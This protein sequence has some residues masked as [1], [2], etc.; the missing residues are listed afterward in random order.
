VGYVINPD[1]E[2]LIEAASLG[3]GQTIYLAWTLVL[4]N[5]VN[6]KMAY[7]IYYSTEEDQVFKEGVK[8]VSIDG[9]LS[10]NIPDFIPGQ[11]Y[12]FAVRG[13]EYDP[14]FVDLTLL[15]DAFNGLKVYPTSL[16]RSDIGATD[17]LIPLV[18]TFDFPIFGIVQVGVELVFYS[19]ID[20]NNDNLNVPSGTTP[21]PG[22]L[23]DQGGGNFY[24]PVAGNHGT[25]TI[26]GLALVNVNSPAQIWE[27]KCIFVQ[28]DGSGNPIAGTAKFEAIGSISD[29]VRNQ[30]GDPF[31]WPVYNQT[32]SN[33]NLSFSISE[34]TTFV[35]GDTFIVVIGG[36]TEAVGMGRGFDNTIAR[37]HQTDGYDGYNT[38]N[39]LVSFWAGGDEEHNTVIFPCQSRFE[40]PN[41]AFTLADGYHQETKDLLT[42]DL[43]ASDASNVNFPHYDYAGWHRTNPLDLLTGVCVGSYIGG[44]LYCADGYDG[45]GRQVRGMSLQDANNNR[46]EI[47]LAVTGEPVCLVRRLWTGITCNC[48]IPESEYPD[49]RCPQCFGTKMV[50]G[51]EQYFN[52]R[53]ADGR[54]MVRFSPTDD[55]VKQYEGGLESEFTSDCWTLVVPAVKDRDFIVRFD[56][57]GNEEYRYE[58]L[59]T[60]R[61]KTI[62]TLSGAQ[63]FRV[64]RIRKFDPIYQVP[65]F[66]NTQYFPQSATTTITNAFGIGP[67]MHTFQTNENSPS[68]TN[69]LTGVSAGHNHP[70][71]WNGGKWIVQ[72][73]LGHTHGLVIPSPN[74]TITFPNPENDPTQYPPYND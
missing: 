21:I 1:I 19:S 74:E 32:I 39:P 26:N 58:I 69:Q 8:F 56:Q 71:L 36:P 47:L 48:Y 4:P 57:N 16:L 22:H 12:H 60:N 29:S 33:G 61:N 27:I 44:E 65:V 25:G 52:P 42:T 45:V 31:V 55:D 41:F 37:M 54:I 30:Y 51:W 5:S 17:L 35:P 66:R 40:Y 9:S 59:Y 43:S 11:L 46:Q 13:V 50:I 20:Q 14:G 63:K 18:D 28:R 53:R 3:D 34:T 67:H 62:D 7:H 24:T 49:D 38:W 70:I 72:E 73:V 2:G 10:V 64:Q 6:N 23:V 15:P 68:P